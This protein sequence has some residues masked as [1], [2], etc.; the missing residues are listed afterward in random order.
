MAVQVTLSMSLDGYITG[1]KVSADLP[2]GTAANVLRPG[3]DLHKPQ[4]I[5]AVTGATVVGRTIYD[6]TDGWGEEPPFRMP[7]FVVT[8][9]ARPVRIAGETTFTF[10]G[11][12]AEAVAEAKQAAGDKDVYIGGGA[13]I[14]DQALNLDLV[15]E[16]FLY[17]EPVLLGG[18]TR[19]FASLEERQ[20][21]LERVRAVEAPISTHI[22]YRV[23]R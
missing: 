7:V 12:V 2:L 5:L 19:L 17:I 18:G 11:S 21:T 4:D 10:V 8:H 20:I 23:L 1:P 15:D 16:L 13:S 6:H 22:H 14:A 9:R 3:G